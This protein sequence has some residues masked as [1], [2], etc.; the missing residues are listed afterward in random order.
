MKKINDYDLLICATDFYNLTVGDK[1]CRISCLS[2]NAAKKV[3]LAGVR[4]RN[5]I[6]VHQE[7]QKMKDNL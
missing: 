4:L 6:K 2:E 3:Q 1:E 7:L 5:A